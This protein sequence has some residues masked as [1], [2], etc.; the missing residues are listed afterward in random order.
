L[1]ADLAAK[2]PSSP[3]SVVLNGTS[4][5]AN[6]F[7]WAGGTRLVSPTNGG[8]RVQN[9][10]GSSTGFEAYNTGVVQCVS[11]LVNAGQPVWWP[12][13]VQLK[14]IAL[15]RLGLYSHDGTTLA[16]LECSTVRLGVYTDLTLPTPGVPGRI[17][18]SSDSGLVH[19]N[20]T[21]WRKATYTNV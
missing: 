8:L 5:T 17:A 7:G 9:A 19:D 4:T 15:G 6:A 3:A 13:H 12:S 20:G 18:Y 16:Q 2:M 11:A 10:A 1:T 21:N 14:S